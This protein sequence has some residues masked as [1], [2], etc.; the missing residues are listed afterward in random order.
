[1]Y[2]L[3]VVARDYCPSGT[4]RKVLGEVLEELTKEIPPKDAERLVPVELKRVIESDATLT[5]DLTAYNI[6]PL[7]APTLT[8][9]I[10]SFPREYSVPATRD[11]DMFDYLQYTFVVSAVQGIQSRSDKITQKKHS[12]ERYQRDS[13]LYNNNN[14]TSQ[15]S[16][17]NDDNS[18]TI[19]ENDIALQVLELKKLLYVLRKLLTLKAMRVIESADLLLYD[20][21]V[22]NE[23]LNLVRGDARLLYVGKTDGYH[24]RTQVF[25]RGGEEMEFCNNKE[26]K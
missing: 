26:F 25:G 7:D 12:F 6:I 23:V 9:A 22:S 14:T 13:W 1:M 10:V 24:S 3:G 17:Q 2:V 11:V 15:C 16:L 21:L 8:N 4:L 20:R 19:R 18:N 5:E